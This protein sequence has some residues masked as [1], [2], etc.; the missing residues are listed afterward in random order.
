MS[1]EKFA[2]LETMMEQ[3]I[4]AIGN[5]GAELEEV[6]TNMATKT[7]LEEVKTNMAT[8]TELADIKKEIIAINSRLVQIENVH[9]TKLTAL[10]DGFELRGDEVNQLKEHLDERLDALQTDLSY[11]V[12]KVAQHD[13]NIVQ[14]RKQ[15][16]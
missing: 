13:R 5:I 6:K 1:E 11:V 10:A 15:A 7:E 8:K 12:S 3:L 16:K 2:R 14:L 9:G 4:R